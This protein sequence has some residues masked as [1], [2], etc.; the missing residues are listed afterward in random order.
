MHPADIAKSIHDSPDIAE[1]RRLFEDIASSSTKAHVLSEL[2]SEHVVQVL[3]GIPLT[4][5]S[6]L[7]KEL[8]RDDATDILRVL[9]QEA[10]PAILRGIAHEEAAQLECLLTYP[11][12][13]AGGVMTTQYVAIHQDATVD[14][15]FKAIQK[16]S[17]EEMIYEIY[18]TNDQGNL[19]GVVALRAL[20]R[21]SRKARITEI[22][23]RE[24]I[25]VTTETNQE[26]VADKVARY[27]LLSIPVVH[28]TGKLMGIITIDDV[29][30]VIQ[31]ETTEDMLRMSGISTTEQDDPQF[32][33]SGL[34]EAKR[35]L[36][37]IFVNMLGSILAGYILWFFRYTIQEVV[38]IISFIPIITAL[39]GNA[40]LQSS[41]LVIRSL[42][43]GRI[44]RRDLWTLCVRES[45]VALLMGSICGGGI[46]LIT[47]AWHAHV[48]LGVVVGFS[49]T[50]T[51][52]I[53]VVMATALPILLKYNGLDPAIAAAPLITT[54]TDIASITIY[55]MTATVLLSSL[56]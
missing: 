36:P 17:I 37:W 30:D 46:L 25:F 11:K 12:R 21:A 24:P 9:P 39:G 13:S 53:A 27:N 10:V 14:T 44:D 22:M 28:P 26:E 3:R 49:M 23:D 31:E 55:L 29:V 1:K 33:V 6:A 38:A 42:A 50:L 54:A 56:S 15:A 45:W 40:G 2:S 51:F 32:Y 48:M 43:I 34:Q 52:L 35:R 4:E 16:S 18:V 5:L 47:L 19:M 8:P 41:T 20:L 7:I